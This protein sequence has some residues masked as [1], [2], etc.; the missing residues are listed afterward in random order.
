WV[1]EVAQ[2]DASHLSEE[3]YRIYGFEPEQGV[4]VWEQRLQRVHPEDRAR[5]QDVIER[6]ITER[7][8]YEVEFRII[9]PSGAVKHIHTVGHPVLN[10][11]GD[12]DQFVGSSTDIT[13]RKQAE[14]ALRQAQT[15]LARINRVTTMGELTASLAHEV[16]QPITAAVT[17]A[18]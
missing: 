6:A 3:W 10:A 17:D 13:E 16:N 2:R 8:G 12:L 14:E 4:P 11:S 18:N 9:L 7:S 1:W 15:D 5:Y